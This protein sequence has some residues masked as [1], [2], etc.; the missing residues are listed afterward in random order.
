VATASN[1]HRLG[2]NEAPPAII[3]VYLGSQLEKVFDQISQGQIGGSD[4]PGLMD[5][6]VDTLPVFPKDPAIAIVPLPL[7]LR[8]IALNS[9]PWVLISQFPGRWWR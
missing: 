4:A 6:G 3:S 2:A 1:D 7:L 5:L 8:A 9:A